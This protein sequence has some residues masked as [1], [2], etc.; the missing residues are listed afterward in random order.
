MTDVEPLIRTELESLMP[1]PEGSRRDWAD[2]LER[3][4]GAPKILPV[5]HTIGHGV[6]A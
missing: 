4:G 6:P 1:L 3:S 5:H 2:V